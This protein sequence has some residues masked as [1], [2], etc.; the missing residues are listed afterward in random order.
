MQDNYTDNDPLETQEWEESIDVVVERAGADRARYLLKKA[1][2]KAYAAGT[3]PPDTNHTPYLNTIPVHREKPYPGDLE[4]EHNLRA[5]VRWN[6]AAMV[7]RANKKPAEPGG[8]IAS[9]QSSAT[10]YEVGMNHFWHA[11]SDEHGGDLIYFQ[12]HVAPGMYSRAFLAGRLE[13]EQIEHFRREVDGKGVSSYPHPWLMPD[14][15]Q[16][17][18]VSMGLGP[19]MALYQARFMKYLHNREL[20]DASRRN[21]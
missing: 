20:I 11:P 9:F 3:E 19:L 8:H 16:F 17:P 15:W 4:L 13:E 18:T 5:Y 2:D 1:V 7:V 14:F 10:F 6:A 21:V 12:G